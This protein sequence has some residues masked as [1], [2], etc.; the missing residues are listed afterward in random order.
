MAVRGPFLWIGRFEAAPQNR[1]GYGSLI[2]HGLPQAHVNSQPFVRIGRTAG[3]S[4]IPVRGYPSLRV[5]G[6][7]VS[8]FISRNNL[9]VLNAILST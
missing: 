4:G 8:H 7:A 9:L 2:R 1:R 3:D 5:F 6:R